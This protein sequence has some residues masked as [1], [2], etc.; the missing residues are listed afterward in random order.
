M[1][2]FSTLIYLNVHNCVFVIYS[3]LNDK[4]LLLINCMNVECIFLIMVM[5]F[6]LQLN[7]QVSSSE[8]NIV[9]QNIFCLGAPVSGNDK[10]SHC[11]RFKYPSYVQDI[12]GDVFSLGFGPFRFA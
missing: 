8:I 12:M 4:L 1:K 7:K 3:V 5:D 9:I 2:G 11:I 6:Y 10:G